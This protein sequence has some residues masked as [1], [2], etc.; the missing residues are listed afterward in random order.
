[1]GRHAKTMQQHLLGLAAEQALWE[2]L[3]LDI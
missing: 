2:E 1:M 3:T